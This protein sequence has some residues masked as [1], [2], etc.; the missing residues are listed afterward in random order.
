[1]PAVRFRRPARRHRWRTGQLTAATRDP[2]TRQLVA[3][4]IDARTGGTRVLDT[5]R[6]DLEVLDGGRWRPLEDW[7]DTTAPLFNT[8]QEKRS[9]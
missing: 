7:A 3:E 1:M 9:R 4:V 5:D 6:L 2:D 8:D